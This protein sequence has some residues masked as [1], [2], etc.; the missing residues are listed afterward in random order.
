[1][2][3]GTAINHDGYKEQG[4]S[5]PSAEAQA[6]LMTSLYHKTGSIPAEVDYVECHGTGTAIG[7]PLEIEALRQVIGKNRNHQCY[8]G[9]VKT[10]IGHLEGA[11]GIVGLIK[12]ALIL[13][14]NTIPPNLH[15]NQPRAELRLKESNFV[16][17]TEVIQYIKANGKPIL[18][19]VNSFGAG[20][21][22]AH[23]ILSE[24]IPKE[25]KSMKMIEDY[26]HSNT[27]CLLFL[28]TDQSE[29]RLLSTAKTYVE[30][31]KQT[32]HDISDICYTL[33]QRRSILSKQLLITGYS[34]EEI[35]D[36]LEQYID[37]KQH[38]QILKKQSSS[39]REKNDHRSG[40]KLAFAYSGQGGQ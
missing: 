13:S 4:Y 32:T 24:F 23:A 9:S 26:M 37:G 1:M 10:N 20:G 38:S 16:V 35:I 8:I 40:N 5:V 25:N 31:L 21:A 3:R 2:I 17:P 22:N 27:T 29:S 7:D 28:L 30:Y 34:K 11:A 18:A 12:A 39:A 36:L 33:L 6:S 19:G 15:F 14:H